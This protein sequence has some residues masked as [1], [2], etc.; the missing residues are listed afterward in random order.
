MFASDHTCLQ[1]LL[2]R[3][4]YFTRNIYHAMRLFMHMRSVTMSSLWDRPAEK[5]IQ[6]FSIRFLLASCHAL[7]MLSLRACVLM[8]ACAIV[9]RSSVRYKLAGIN[10]AQHIYGS[11]MDQSRRK[12]DTHDHRRARRVH[13]EHDPPRMSAHN[14]MLDSS[15]SSEYL[16]TALIR[17]LGVASRAVASGRLVLIIV[18][19]FLWRRP[20]TPRLPRSWRCADVVN[21][22]S[23]QNLERNL[24]QRHAS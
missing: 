16:W 20:R 14:N 9:D 2:K 13:T 24:D 22:L 11:G 15:L 8:K 12:M 17:W 7:P 23:K 6:L 5:I 10:S 3:L 21:T 18:L 19:P 1:H 4:W